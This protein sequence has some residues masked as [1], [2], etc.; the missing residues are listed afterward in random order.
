[1]DGHIRT[2]KF[3]LTAIVRDVPSGFWSDGLTQARLVY[4]DAFHE[5]AAD[6]RILPE[7]RRDMLLQMRH[8]RMQHMLSSLAEKHGLARSPTVLA[9]NARA[10]AYVAK[11]DIGMT[12]AYVSDIGAMPQP[13]KFRER[14]AAKMALPRLDLGDEPAEVMIGKYFYGLLAHNPVGSRFTEDDQKLGT[15]QFCLPAGDCKAWAVELTIP[16]IVQAYEAVTPIAK[17]DRSLPW[18]VVRRKEEGE[19]Q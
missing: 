13:A 5:V 14:F 2:R 3:V 19:G 12:Q 10:I 6:S 16:E 1:M 4:L 18:K 17:P 8:F 15:M 11:G 9:E 7:Q